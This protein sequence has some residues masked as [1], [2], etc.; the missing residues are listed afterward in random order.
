MI[1]KHRQGQG[2]QWG[3]G[4]VTPLSGENKGGQ[5]PCAHLSGR[6]FGPY[7]PVSSGSFCYAS[8]L[9][10]VME[11]LPSTRLPL[12]YFTDGPHPYYLRPY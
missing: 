9:L 4:D 10:D 12:S 8:F 6:T 1:N 11:I 2:R 5:R 7:L 3:K